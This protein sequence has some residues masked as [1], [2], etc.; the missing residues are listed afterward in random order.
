MSIEEKL[1]EIDKKLDVL[2]NTISLQNSNK[3]YSLKHF[4]M[5]LGITPYLLRKYYNEYNLNIPSPFRVGRKNPEYNGS[6]LLY[7]RKWLLLDKDK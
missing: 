6:E 5:E 1:I 2:L 7:M 3:L 4:C